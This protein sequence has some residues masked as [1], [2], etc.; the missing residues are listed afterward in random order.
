MRPHAPTRMW[1]TCG[2]ERS[3]FMKTKETLP[4]RP[5]TEP[6]PESPSSPAALF[7]IHTMHN[8]PRNRRSTN[9]IVWQSALRQKLVLIW[10]FRSNFF[11]TVH[12]DVYCQNT[13]KSFSVINYGLL[14]KTGLL[15][16]VDTKQLIRAQNILHSSVDIWETLISSLHSWVQILHFLPPAQMYRLTKRYVLS[17][18]SSILLDVSGTIKSEIFWLKPLLAFYFKT[19][20]R[21]RLNTT[22]I[23]LASKHHESTN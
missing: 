19:C 8:C 10:I 22:K 14:S 5:N 7:S 17:C 21:I 18:C 3:V 4:H 2:F 11:T 20:V 15:R 16:I 23:A 1:S 13:K 9:N 12:F 6:A